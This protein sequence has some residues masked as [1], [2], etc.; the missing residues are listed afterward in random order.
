MTFFD[1]I[2][3]KWEQILIPLA[4]RQVAREL[5]RLSNN[6][7][8][9]TL[10]KQ[11]LTEVLLA[12]GTD[13]DRKKADKINES[14]RTFKDTV[15]RLR[16]NLRKFTS[17]LPSQYQDEGTK[18]EQALFTGLSEK[19]RTLDEIARQITGDNTF[20]P[21]KIKGESSRMVQKVRELKEITDK[22]IARLEGTAQPR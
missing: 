17:I 7:D 19:W 14:I 16:R 11:E 4:R 18:V 13:L 8:D 3:K 22:L 10:D 6:L 9:L 21:E 15:W 1:S 5:R 12:A 2:S 20:D